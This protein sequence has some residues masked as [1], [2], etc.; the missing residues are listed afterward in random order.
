MAAFALIS[1]L[2]CFFGF[3]DLDAVVESLFVVLW[4]H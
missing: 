3:V 1:Y 2:Q 4:A